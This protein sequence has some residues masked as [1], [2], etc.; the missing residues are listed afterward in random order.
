M[1]LRR[2][3]WLIIFIINVRI[4][5][6]IL[7]NVI[8]DSVHIKVG[9]LLETVFLRLLFLL[10]MDD[11]F[12]YGV[13]FGLVVVFWGLVVMFRWFVVVFRWLVVVFVLIVV[14]YIV[15]FRDMNG[16]GMDRGDFDRNVRNMNIRLIEV[17]GFFKMNGLFD[18]DRL[19]KVDG[20]V[21]VDRLL[22]ID[23]LFEKY[24]LFE[25]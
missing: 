9:Q 5:R 18:M 13:V 12:H 8:Y 25:N 7:L 16:N 11:M 14:A 10:V 24:R 22:E 3:L 15:V 1:N 23:R 17:N 20:F 2:I 19:F 21:K 6:Q 4:L